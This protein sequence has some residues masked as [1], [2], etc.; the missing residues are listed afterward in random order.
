[1]V[2]RWTKLDPCSGVD[3]QYIYVTRPSLPPTSQAPTYLF[4]AAHFNTIV[5]HVTL[6]SIVEHLRARGDKYFWTESFCPHNI[7]KC[8]LQR[9]GANMDNTT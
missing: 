3:T 6:G 8:W 4:F 5:D 2:G 7:S 1:M 9:R